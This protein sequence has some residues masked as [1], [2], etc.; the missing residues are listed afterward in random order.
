MDILNYIPSKSINIFLSAGNSWFDSMKNSVSWASVHS[1]VLTLASL[2]HVYMVQES[3]R[4]LNEVYAQ[5]LGYLLQ[6]SLF[7]G[8]P[9]PLTS[10]RLLLLQ[11][12]AFDTSNQKNCRF[13]TGVSMIP[14]SGNCGLLLNQKLKVRKKK[15]RERE[16][17]FQSVSSGY[18][19]S[20]GIAGS[21]GSLISSFLRNFHTV[22][23]SGCISLH[24][25]Q[26]CKRVPFSLHPLQH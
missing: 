21:Y 14:S 2:F 3:A 5:N 6:L 16:K 20:S 9:P 19:S 25:H 22:L 7:S 12:L 17:P 10:Q 24:S 1:V 18:I 4:D 8:S 11:P 13:S 26:Q 15:K 23:H